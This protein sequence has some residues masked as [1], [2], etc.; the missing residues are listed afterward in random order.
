MDGPPA[1]RQAENSAVP[2]PIDAPGGARLPQ[3]DFAQPRQGRLQAPP[4][5]ARD[6]F[7]GRIFQ[8][9]DVIEVA[10]V[11]FAMD[12]LASRL[13]VGEVHDP[14]GVG[15][16]RPRHG[17]GDA[18]GMAMQ[19]ETLVAVGHVGQQVRGLE[20]ELVEDFHGQFFK[21]CRGTYGF[22]G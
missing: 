18:K 21:G 6:D 17:E 14:A 11:E 20:G 7:A 9:F 2:A 8:A 22:A 16:D 12:R 15:V 13:D 1:G 4:D 5:P 19:A 3:F 10:V